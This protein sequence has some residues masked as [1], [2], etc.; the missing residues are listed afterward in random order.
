M[1]LHTA[2][3][4]EFPV[5]FLTGMEDGIF[6]HQR[7]FSD[8][9][10]LAEE[11]RLAYVGITRARE[12]LYLSRAVTRS[13]WGQANSYPA[14]RFLDDVP[15][16]L[17]DWRRLAPA[18]DPYVPGSAD[19]RSSNWG[20][21]G[22]SNYSGYDSRSR[23]A[24]V[25]ASRFGQVGGRQARPPLQLAVGDRVSHDK[26]G[27]GKVTVMSGSGPDRDGHHR[28]RDG[29]HHP[30]DADRWRADDQARDD[31]PV[32]RESGD[33]GRPELDADPRSD[34]LGRLRD[35]VFPGPL[36]RPAHHHQVAVPDRNPKPGAAG[37]AG[38][39]AADAPNRRTGWRPSCPNVQPRPMVSPCQA[40]LSRPSRYRQR[41]AV[42]KGSPSSSL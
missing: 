5:V 28:L 36:T 21:G 26:Y 19:Y 27:L 13:A 38:A 16:E 12:R 10:E 2:K 15:E 41:P 37:S 7:A 33:V 32:P 23:S 39:G 18:R 14:S 34:R 35:R 20:S 1:T 25:S 30:A 4:L 22:S 11:R 42:R 9:R 31:C 17:I 24:P 8:E 6:P 40:T 3:G 29:R